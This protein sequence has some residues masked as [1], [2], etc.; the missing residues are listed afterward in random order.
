MIALYF[1]IEDI[2]VTHEADVNR[3]TLSMELSVFCFQFVVTFW[4]SVLILGMYSLLN[5]NRPTSRWT[6]LAYIISIL[7]TTSSFGY[8]YYQNLQ[9]LLAARDLNI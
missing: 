7:V 5:R 6:T 2:E 4:T 3:K 9:V 1:V 8:L